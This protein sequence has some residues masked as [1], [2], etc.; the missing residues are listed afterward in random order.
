MLSE[1]GFSCADFSLNAYLS[2]DS[3]Y[4]MERNDFFGQPV[5]DLER[6]FMRHKRGAKEAGVTI[7][8]MHMPS[9]IYVPEGVAGGISEGRKEIND[10]LWNVV[11]PKSMELCHFLECPS[12]VVHGFKL[13]GLLGSEEA[14]WERTE[15]FIGFLAPMAR[16]MGIT[17]CME[18]LF[19]RSDCGFVKGPACD[20]QKAVERIDRINEMFKAQVLGFCFDTGHANLA[21]IDPGHFVTGL[22]HRLKVLHLHDNDKTGDL[23]QIPYTAATGKE[24]GEAVHWDSLIEGLRNIHFGGVLSFETAPAL[25]AFPEEIK[26]D[27]LR[28]I[29]GIGE[30][31]SRRIEMGG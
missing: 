8:Q 4:R 20:M 17:V 7:S 27:V 29:A 21:G 5:K 13:A 30:Y 3:I 15:A 9:P 22:G 6:Y 25:C 19:D 31:F 12:I 10:Y 28:L 26:R 2:N 14:E 16:D 24:N 18:N 11:A 1:T 23:H